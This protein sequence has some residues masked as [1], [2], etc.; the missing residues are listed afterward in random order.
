MSILMHTMELANDAALALPMNL[1]DP[2]AI[3]PPG[4][5]KVST[6]MGW[7]KWIALVICILSLMAA[8]ARMSYE[9]R[10]GGGG[11]H[12][13]TIMK[14]LFGVIIISAASAIVGFII[15]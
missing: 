6:V 10:H 13:S 15:S 12:V 5:G 8:G 11:E 3:Q 7:G 9:Q 2:D 1:P 4:T 14:V